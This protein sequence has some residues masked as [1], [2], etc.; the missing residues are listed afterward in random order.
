M[1]AN[2]FCQ[3]CT[4]LWDG[5]YSAGASASNTIS[6]SEDTMRKL[7]TSSSSGLTGFESSRSTKMTFNPANVADLHSDLLSER[8]RMSDSGS[9]ILDAIF[10]NEFMCWESR[11]L[12]QRKPPTKYYRKAFVSVS[13]EKESKRTFDRSP[14]SDDLKTF[15]CASSGADEIVNK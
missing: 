10:L 1:L 3:R 9:P 6:L 5:S 2:L 11:P 4:S 14:F 13:S 8:K 12:V 15:S 7:F